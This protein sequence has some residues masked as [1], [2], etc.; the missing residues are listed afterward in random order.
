MADELEISVAGDLAPLEASF[1]SLPAMAEKAA[2]SVNDAFSSTSGTDRLTDSVE[3][4]GAALSSNL[5]PGAQSASAALEGLAEP[6]QAAS[7]GADA[8][9][10]SIETLSG[11]LGAMQASLNEI[12][13][14]LHEV[15]DAEHEI[16]HNSEEAAGGI[17]HIAESLEKAK[18]LA[19]A[20]IAVALAE[21]LIELGVE[22]VKVFGEGERVETSFRLMSGSAKEASETFERLKEMSVQLGIPL[23]DMEHAG[24]RLAAVFGIGEGLTDVMNAAAN[25]S[26]ATGRSFETVA[27][28]LERVQLTGQVSARQ[29][30]ALGV[31]WEDLAKTMGVS[32][33]EAQAML[34]KGGQ[35]AEKDIEALLATIKQKYGNAAAEQARGIIGQMESLKNQTEILMEEIGKALL[36]VAQAI[37]STMRDTVVPAIASV[38][39]EF[40]KLPEPAKESTLVVG[41]LAASLVPLAAALSGLGFALQGATTLL[42]TFGI[43][44]TAAGAAAAAGWAALAVV[45]VAA[46]EQL[47]AGFIRM[48]NAQ[49]DLSDATKRNNDQ[50]TMLLIDMRKLGIDTTDL[51]SKFSQ[52]LIS[53]T[54]YK[55]GLSE[56]VIKFRELHPV[57]Q[58]QSGDQDKFAAAVAEAA[59]KIVSTQAD[60]Q[61]AYEVSK[62]AFELLTQKYKEGEASANDVTAAHV[63]MDK[64]FKAL[65]QEIPDTISSFSKI[66]ANAAKLADD[67]ARAAAEYQKALV[68]FQSGKAT[69]AEVN[70][71]FDQLATSARAAH[72]PLQDIAHDSQAVADKANEQIVALKHA[73]EVYNDLK[74]IGDKSAAGQ[75]A[76]GL[77]LKD[78]QKS[79]TEVGLTAKATGDALEFEL[80]AKAVKAGTAS[81]NLR[82][83][84]NKVYGAGETLG[85]MVNGKLVPY[86]M[87]LADSEGKAAANGSTLSEAT[88]KVYNDLGQLADTVKVLSYEMDKASASET[89][90][91][92]VV[93]I[94]L[95]GIETAADLLDKLANEYQNVAD[96]AET[97]AAAVADESAAE[98]KSV[99]T[100]S[101]RGGG[102][103][104]TAAETIA[105]SILS[106][107]N[108]PA[109]AGNYG[110]GGPGAFGNPGGPVGLGGDPFTITVSPRQHSISASAPSSGALPS[111]G[112]SPSL[113]SLTQTPS[114]SINVSA[115]TVVGANGMQ[116]LSD[117]I[118][119]Q[120]TKQ[121]RQVGGLKL[122]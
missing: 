14:S 44:L 112:S 116:Q 51:D 83:E 17:E 53:L 113:S 9:A 86:L 36:P 104:S 41:T 87:N 71:A 35:D 8:A 85:V 3:K 94:G 60:L 32:V 61:K 73:V 11:Q 22:A 102:G 2:A 68:A 42:S 54:A 111:L 18:E 98:T 77:A 13:Q 122:Q 26:A 12:S 38:V 58:E 63:A 23:S 55:Q 30:V 70:T 56:L 76:L 39:K 78:V 90:F 40:Q 88:V 6:E 100:R 65:N 28:S 79:A 19:E 62:G 25:A 49:D 4:A 29:L 80:A 92:D 105:A 20:F 82:D 24:Q 59:K 118:I 120:F 31:S 16:E 84:F 93:I 75:L 69:M 21:K 99:S 110:F 103:S 108:S 15:V 66:Q 107:M 115:G 45:G 101:G 47:V 72:I 5:T 27:Q 43:T 89:D 7:A 52:G 97:A 117:M 1:E 48:K 74:D 119:A 10:A 64:A 50:L 96:K 34:K 37:V 46:V 114:L 33:E 95:P 57:V 67:T 81:A 121:I 106:G 109:T 91:N